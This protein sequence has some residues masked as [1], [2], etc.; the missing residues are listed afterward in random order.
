MDVIHAPQLSCVV[1]GSAGAARWSKEEK[2]RR[3]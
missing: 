3:R 2:L 1:R